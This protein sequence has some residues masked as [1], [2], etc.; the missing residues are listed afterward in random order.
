MVG[1]AGESGSGKSTLAYAVTRLLRDPGIIT[2]GEANYYDWP[3][4]S[5]LDTSDRTVT[6]RDVLDPA[7][8]RIVDLLD[9]RSPG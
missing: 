2:A 8:P 7:Q 1:L 4:G 3:E 6:S 9:R 5:Y